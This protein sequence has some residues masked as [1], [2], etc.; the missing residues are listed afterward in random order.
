MY[1][2]Y[3]CGIGVFGTELIKAEIRQALFILV[4]VA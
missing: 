2:I 3:I 4:G 1:E